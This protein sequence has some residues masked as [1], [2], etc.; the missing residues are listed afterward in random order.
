MTLGVLRDCLLQVEP[1]GHILCRFL[2]TM[3]VI[4]CEYGAPDMDPEMSSTKAKCTVR[5]L[6]DAIACSNVGDATALG[7]ATTPSRRARS[8][9]P[10]LYFRRKPS[11]T[12]F[13]RD[14]EHS[15]FY[16]VPDTELWGCHQTV[17]K[18]PLP[19]FV[20]L[21]MTSDAIKNVCA[22]TV[23]ALLG[24]AH[25]TQDIHAESTVYAPSC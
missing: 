10:S 1:P 21:I 20:L 7:T 12:T 24:R 4:T 13:S 3:P 19:T 8:A 9:E 17:R 15:H 2:G 16:C 6:G 5:T 11:I 14:S 23:C 18:W 25:D 22:P